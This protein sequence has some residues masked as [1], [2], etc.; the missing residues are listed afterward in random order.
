MNLIDLLF[1]LINDYLGDTVDDTNV[2]PLKVYFCLFKVGINVIQDADV[3]SEKMKLYN[4]ILCKAA[5]KLIDNLKTSFSNANV[6][7]AQIY[8]NAI[9]D[10]TVLSKDGMQKCLK[11]TKQFSFIEYLTTESFLKIAY[12]VMF[13]GYPNETILFDSGNNSLNEIIYASK[14]NIIKIMSNLINIIRPHLHMEK[15]ETTAF[16]KIL[17]S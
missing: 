10:W 2:H 17:S 13:L 6:Q 3:L 7:E 14:A 9:H 11:D 4:K 5:E 1:T 8:T 12:E 16:G 15:L